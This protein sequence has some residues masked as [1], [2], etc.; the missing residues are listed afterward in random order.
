MFDNW[1]SQKFS[2]PN[3]L[4]SPLSYLSTFRLEFQAHKRKV[5]KLSEFGGFKCENVEQV[6]RNELKSP[7]K[8]LK[9]GRI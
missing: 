5:A 3:P 6:L 7:D 9:D 1:Q 4:P 8:R 2:G